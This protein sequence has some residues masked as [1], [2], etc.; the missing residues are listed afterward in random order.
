MSSKKIKVAIIQLTRIGDLIQTMQSV[1]QLKAEKDNIEFTLIARKQFSQG[2]MF[3]L[4]TV[5]DD[6]I[7][8]DT[9][10]FFQKKTFK[11]AKVSTHN[12]LE[13][14]NSLNID[15]VINLSFSKSSSYLAS[16]ISCKHQMG[17]SRSYKNE[18]V[19]NDKWSQYT[20]SSVMNTSNNPFSLVDIYRYII[21]SNQAF[22]LNSSDEDHNVNNIVIHPFA[23]TKKKKWG[24]NKWSELIYKLAQDNSEFNFTIVGGA[25][26]LEEAKRIVEIPSLKPFNERIVLKINEQISDVY[27]TLMNSKLFIGHDSMVSHLACETVTPSIIISLGTVRPNET[28]PYHENVINIIPKNSCFPC[29]VSDK[30]DLLP[31]HNSIN[32][33][34]VSTIANGMIKKQEIDNSFLNKNLSP[35][36]YDLLRIYKSEFYEDGISFKEISNNHHN[37]QDTFREYYKIIWQF[38]LRGEEVQSSLPDITIE[39]AKKLAPYVEGANYLFELYNFGLKYSNQIVEECKSTIPSADNIKS[40]INKLAEIDQLC[41]VTKDK[42]PLLKDLVDFF[43]VSKANP[44]G[45][46]ILDISKHNLVSYHDA[47][48]LTSV[49]N[50]FIQSTLKPFN[51]QNH[52]KRSEL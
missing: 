13:K 29:K 38:Y 22:K 3:L 5:F 6:I 45:D 46:S 47:S 42:Y 41:S 12:F 7:T 31:C 35:Y 26:D 10:D 11:S 18:V 27:K 15:L 30:C 4:E 32:F 1:R 51:L 37:L 24:A 28:T 19:I 17:L 2:I 9:K 14:L 25:A 48:N 23:S 40:N 20:Y 33:Q 36:Q 44:V 43:Y 16:L 21:G 8:F 39:T 34:T 50:D 49:L 52:D